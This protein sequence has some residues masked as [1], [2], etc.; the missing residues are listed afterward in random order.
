[1]VVTISPQL[2][3]AEHTWRVL[4]GVLIVGV[5]IRAGIIFGLGTA[6]RPEAFEYD[7]LARNL[8]AGQ[9][10]T[11]QHLGTTYRSF[12]SALPYTLL[13]AG[14][15]ALVP[16][17]QVALLLLQSVF[18]GLLGFVVFG[19][20]R[21][22]LSEHVG[23]LSAVLVVLHPALAY[24]D[25][26][27]LH[28]LSFDALVVAFAT[29]ALLSLSG[30]PSVSRS[31]LVG[32]AL[33]VAILQR[34]TMVLLVPLVGLSLFWYLRLHRKGWLACLAFGVGLVLVV[35]PWLARSYALY[36]YPLLMTTTA[37][38][39]W[40][41]NVAHSSGG[42]Y[43]PSGRTVLEDA[44]EEF[45]RDLLSRDEWGQYQLF[46]REGLL[47][48]R[49]APVAFVGKLL[50]KFVYFW[51]FAPQ[52]GLLYPPW[53]LYLY[54]AYY[55]LIGG[56]AVIGARWVARVIR[57]DLKAWRGFILLV[58]VWLCVSVGQSIFYVE[59]RHRWAVEP[60]LL[61]LTSIGWLSLTKR[62]GD[63]VT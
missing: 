56:L 39:F 59:L 44:P 58:A 55:A 20:A 1:M 45:R 42:S 10:Y 51:T 9:G 34:G 41:G 30:S 35:A 63:K 28:P 50:R 16:G 3:P 57:N 5:L 31:L 12:H 22:V 7:E 61:I 19:I 54:M 38:H 13:T 32:L 40:R 46:L 48:V 26:H 2:R 60:L 52:T 15:Y 18:S 49:E 17:G 8:L 14:V 29:Y 11:I 6:W 23:V 36:G 21:I 62:L 53:Q 33:G 24:Y 37:E 43:L 27:K 47:A 4:L 25:T